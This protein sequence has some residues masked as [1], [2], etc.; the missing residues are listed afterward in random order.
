MAWKV[1]APRPAAPRWQ[2]SLYTHTTPAVVVWIGTGP[3]GCVGPSVR[4]GRGG[5]RGAWRQRLFLLLLQLGPGFGI[6]DDCVPHTPR[7]ALVIL[8]GHGGRDAFERDWG[9]GPDVAWI[10]LGL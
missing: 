10:W 7:R 2:A 1:S 8:H 4:E 6:W 9:V 5:S 3:L